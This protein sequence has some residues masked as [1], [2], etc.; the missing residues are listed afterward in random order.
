VKAT[1]KI[2]NTSWAHVFTVRDGQIA[3]FQEYLDTAAV[4]AELRAAPAAL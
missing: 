3:A 4:M 2:L 1:G